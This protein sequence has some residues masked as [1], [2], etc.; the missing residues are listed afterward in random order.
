MDV[1]A[2][3]SDKRVIDGFDIKFLTEI[4]FVSIWEKT[5]ITQ[6]PFCQPAQ[7]YGTFLSS[8]FIYLYPRLKNLTFSPKID[9]PIGQTFKS[10]PNK[11][12]STFDWN[13]RPVVYTCL[14]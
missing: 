8:F 14:V 3:F 5:V 6:G 13:R 2:S 10:I 11:E 9:L 1:P 4:N 7:A 12:Y